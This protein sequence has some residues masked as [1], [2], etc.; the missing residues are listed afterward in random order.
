VNVFGEQHRRHVPRSDQQYYNR[1]AGMR[2]IKTVISTIVTPI[3]FYQGAGCGVT[4]R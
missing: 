4:R 2:Q 1:S 3:D